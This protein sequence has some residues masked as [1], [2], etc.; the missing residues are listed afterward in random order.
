MDVPLVLIH[1]GGASN[2]VQPD[3]T[4]RWPVE[5]FALLGSRLAREN[6]AR[7]LLVGGEGGPVANRGYCWIDDHHRS[8]FGRRLTLGE[9]GL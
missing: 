8:K 5:R 3:I 6:N 2:P 4:K 7:L 9:L 1:P